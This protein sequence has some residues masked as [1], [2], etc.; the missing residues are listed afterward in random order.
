MRFLTLPLFAVLLAFPCGCGKKDPPGGGSAAA[1]GDSATPSAPGTG[2]ST[3]TPPP[4]PGGTKPGDAPPPPAPVGALPEP[5]KSLPG[6]ALEA[7]LERLE[8]LPV[9]GLDCRID[10]SFDGMI[11]CVITHFSPSL[12]A[13]LEKLDLDRIVI[14]WNTHDGGCPAFTG[15]ALRQLAGVRHVQVPC[16]LKQND[17]FASMTHLKSLSTFDFHSDEIRY[18]KDLHGLRTLRLWTD[19]NRRTPIHQP[20]GLTE[21]RI[22]CPPINQVSL[23]PELFTGLRRLDLTVIAHLDA[24]LQVTNHRDLH[25]CHGV[26]EKF[27]NLESLVLNATP[28]A[29]SRLAGL[30]GLK[31]LVFH[32]STLRSDLM[33]AAVFDRL[34]A[35]LVS[36]EFQLD[37]ADGE[38][39]KAPRLHELERLSW[40]LAPKHFGSFEKFRRLVTLEVSNIGGVQENRVFDAPALEV[41]RYKTHLKYEEKAPFSVGSITRAKKLR[42]V[43]IDNVRMDD[44]SWTGELRSLEELKLD[45]DVTNPELDITM[46]GNLTNLKTLHLD[47]NLVIGDPAFLRKLVKLE[48]L[49][50]GRIALDDLSFLRDLPRLRRLSLSGS[51]VKNWDGLEAA[52][53]LVY[54]NLSHTNF[55]LAEPLGRLPLLRRLN[56]SG[57]QV[58]SLTGLGLLQHLLVLD[59]SSTPVKS[60]FPLA[61]AKNLR[62]L[63]AGGQYLDLGPVK[64]LPL[65][66][67][68]QTDKPHEENRQVA[69]EMAVTHPHFTM[70][71]RFLTPL[72]DRH[73]P[74]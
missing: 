52:R 29:L 49:K 37:L 10:S 63:L 62:E 54:L 34:P 73:F 36:A 11:L 25:S 42:I 47:V 68:F 30:R 16:D 6:E 57:T 61:R 2:G 22:N 70:N 67:Y 53:S 48:E 5:V 71:Q 60:L 20:S 46:I 14:S 8:I 26:L 19:T 74:F 23:A 40:R 4:T 9:P 51:T 1:P 41:Y 32:D 65:L 21:L 7:Y 3:D 15:T 39:E 28:P 55:S 58:R 18:L 33:T 45:V 64:A 31:R 72:R 17:L 66:R 44:L 38:L 69:R 24:D 35:S 50:L 27:A 56:L 43:Q 12:L 59:L 13:D